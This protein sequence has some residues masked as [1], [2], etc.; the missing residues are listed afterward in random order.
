[1]SE[2]ESSV[3][4]MFWD[5]ALLKD[6][7]AYEQLVLFCHDTMPTLYSTFVLTIGITIFFSGHI[8]YEILLPWA[9]YQ[10]AGSLYRFITIRSFQKTAFGQSAIKRTQLKLRL[11]IFL[12]GIGWGIGNLVLSSD[13]P[14]DYKILTAC[15]LPAICGITLSVASVLPST[16][17]YMML[18]IMIP[19]LLVNFFSG[20]NLGYTLGIFGILY[21]VSLLT[22]SKRIHLSS[23]RGL[24]ISLQNEFLK[25][26]ADEASR[27]KSDFLSSVSHE[28]R[29][30][31][32]SVYGFAKVIKKKLDKHLSPLA[33]EGD[34]KLSATLD[35]VHADLDVIIAESE[36]LTKLINDVLDLAKL[37]AGR[38]EMHMESVD[39][40]AVVD[41]VAAAVN[42]LI[43]QKMLQLNVEIESA[44]ATVTGDRDRLIQV[45]LN[46]VSN[47]IKF[48]ERGV[49]TIKV[50]RSRHGKKISVIDT[51]IGIAP[52]NHASVFEKFHQIGDTLT[53]KPKGTGLGLPICK[54]IVEK[55]GGRIWLES[56]MGQGSVFSFTLPG[57]EEG[58]T[59]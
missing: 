27:A 40:K 54:E 29:T 1:M 16:Y 22:T 38:V 32:T 25:K 5:E 17:P 45:L 36:R 46:L 12:A 28:L 15:T 31:M 35:V 59:A 49:I 57:I 50:T 24:R 21:T 3:G 34:E 7:V 26:V 11:G 10:L 47:A 43:S 9:V 8:T 19:F 6:R 48:T 39:L 14:A 52:E 53:D 33:E 18:P 56:K 51:G 2:T 37:D 13:L 42:P 41:H 58:K 30:P 4:E 20:T 55:H 44:D 23:T